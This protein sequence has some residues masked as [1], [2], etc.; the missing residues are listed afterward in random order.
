[1]SGQVWG[2]DRPTN[3]S[4]R[5]PG[6]AAAEGSSCKLADGLNALTDLLGFQ[7][8][9]CPA[10]H[11]ETAALDQ[12]EPSASPPVPRGPDADG[13]LH[14]WEASMNGIIY[15]IGLIVVIMFILSFLGL[16]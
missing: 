16:R 8:C 7:P 2:E 15:L 10:A 4:P 3:M 5:G 9:V 13:R 6:R 14:I 12:V 1:M 11:T